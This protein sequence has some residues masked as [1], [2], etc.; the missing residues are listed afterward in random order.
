M[1]EASLRLIGDYP[2]DVHTPVSDK[3]DWQ[4]WINVMRGPLQTS[5][6]TL[7]EMMEAAERAWKRARGRALRQSLDEFRSWMIPESAL[8]VSASGGASIARQDS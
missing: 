4:V 1:A 7:T 8:P 2:T 5:S 3:W 6:S